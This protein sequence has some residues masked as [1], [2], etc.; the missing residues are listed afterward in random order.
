M[1]TIT[2]DVKVY[3]FMVKKKGLTD[4][5]FHA[6]WREPHGRL[7]K[8]VPQIKRYLQNHGVGSKPTLNGLAATPYLGIPTIWVADLGKLQEI[9][10]DPGFVEVHEDELNLLERDQLA[11]LVTTETVVSE[12]DAAD[13]IGR[14]ATKGLLF[15]AAK[16]GVAADSFRER[17]QVVSETLPMRLGADR[18][19]VAMPHAAA[20]PGDASPLFDAV[21][22][23][24]FKNDRALHEAWERHGAH[25]LQELSLYSALPRSRGFLAREERVI[26][27]P[28]GV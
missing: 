5:E 19:T 11:W 13:D 7:T 27:P 8:K 6:H 4:D 22:E 14:V 2:R 24:G 12:G 3:A 23:I 1:A 25:L 16:E 18:V 15:I 9:N 28:F 26:W 17:V 20:Y 21:I 10:A